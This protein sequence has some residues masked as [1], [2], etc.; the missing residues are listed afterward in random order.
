[1]ETIKQK[2]IQGQTEYL[3]RQK[4]DKPGKQYEYMIKRA[5]GSIVDD[6][7]YYTRQRAEKEF[8]EHIRLTQLGAG[9]KRSDERRSQGFN[10]GLGGGGGGGG[11]P[12]MPDFS[13]GA[14]GMPMLPGFGMGQKDDDDDDEDR[15]FY[16]PGL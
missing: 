11:A 7:V 9:K 14:G 5:N 10:F 13:G 16:I 1:M 8:N 4:T 15:G 12:Q 3:V 6:E 2:T